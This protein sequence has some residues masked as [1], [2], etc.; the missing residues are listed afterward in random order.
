M[1]LR[2]MLCRDSSTRAREC[3]RI[4]RVRA[5]HNAQRKEVEAAKAAALKFEEQAE[6]RSRRK[7]RDVEDED[8]QTS[9]KW[10]LKR[11]KNAAKKR[12]GAKLAALTAIK[13]A[14]RDV[15]SRSSGSELSGSDKSHEERAGHAAPARKMYGYLEARRLAAASADAPA[16][17]TKSTAVLKKLRAITAMSKLQKRTAP[18][19]CTCCDTDASRS[20]PSCGST[21][22]ESTAG[23]VRKLHESERDTLRKQPAE[24][25][26]TFCEVESSPAK[27]LVVPLGKLH[28]VTTSPGSRYTSQLDPAKYRS[29]L[30]HEKHHLGSDIISSKAHFRVRAGLS[31]FGHLGALSVRDSLASV[32]H[33]R[34]EEATAPPEIHR[35]GPRTVLPPF[36]SG[37]LKRKNTMTSKLLAFC[38]FFYGDKL[39]LPAINSPRGTPFQK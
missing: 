31:S 27:S 26:H 11:S 36:E 33:V 7:N 32:P 21:T 22:N 18:L 10:L 8:D 19:A 34:Q 13:G 39:G 12:A 25:F 30:D 9:G 4:T 23:A 24:S 1:L 14:A 16:G 20:C 2:A 37:V 6:K 17:T 35:E 28:M 15:S 5:L 3:A 38:G 29:L